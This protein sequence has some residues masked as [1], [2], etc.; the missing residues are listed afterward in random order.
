MSSTHVCFLDS[1][2]TLPQVLSSY[3]SLQLSSSTYHWFFA[4]QVQLKEDQMVITVK[5]EIDKSPGL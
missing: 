2:V 3:N 5:D 4:S 1:L